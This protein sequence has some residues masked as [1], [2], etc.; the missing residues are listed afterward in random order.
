MN[1]ASWG[2]SGSGG[3]GGGSGDREREGQGL[4]NN[5]K[6]GLWAGI[7]QQERLATDSRLE[8]EGDRNTV[9][10]IR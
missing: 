6:V 1:D 8:P 4:I 2:G 5:Q 7:G 10:I 3:T 9:V